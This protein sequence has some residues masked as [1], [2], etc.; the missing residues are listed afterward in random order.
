MSRKGIAG[1]SH[2]KSRA[3]RSKCR[4]VRPNALDVSMN[5]PTQTLVERAILFKSGKSLL[6]HLQELALLG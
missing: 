6:R 1:V 5:N 2:K 4:G 3:G